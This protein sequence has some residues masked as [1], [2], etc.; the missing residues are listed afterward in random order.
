[1]TFFFL[2][3]LAF[4]SADL[5]MFENQ[6]KA[7]DCPPNAKKKRTVGFVFHILSLK[8]HLKGHYNTNIYSSAKFMELY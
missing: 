6:V 1:M 7:N 4:R 5:I 8:N 3:K 2:R